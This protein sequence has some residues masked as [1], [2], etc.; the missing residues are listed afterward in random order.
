MNRELL[1]VA[2]GALC[3]LASASLAGP[4]P[5]AAPSPAAVK[6]F[7]TE[8]VKAFVSRWF[9]LFERRAP[10]EEAMALVVPEGLEMT[11]PGSSVKSGDEFRKWY[12]KSIAWK[13]QTTHQFELLEVKPSG[14]ETQVSLTVRWSSGP[15]AKPNL[16][17][18]T[19]QS[20]VLVRSGRTGQPLIKVYESRQI[21]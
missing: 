5:A 8:E 14:A 10:V 17:V 1:I 11:F 18:A 20:W 9:S 6:P 16:V 13:E 2:L 3:V 15:P 21:R 4:P 12:G 19:K 7:T